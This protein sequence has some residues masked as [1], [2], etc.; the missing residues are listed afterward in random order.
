MNYSNR[1]LRL[2]ESLEEYRAKID[3]GEYQAHVFREGC[4]VTEIV[5]YPQEKVLT[6]HLLAGRNFDAWKGEAQGVLENF[7]RKNGCVAI[8][9]MCRLGLAKKIESLGWLTTRKIMR[10]TL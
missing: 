2:T 9:A 7:A 3:N 5:Q 10:F 8:E 4:A 6:V 1:K